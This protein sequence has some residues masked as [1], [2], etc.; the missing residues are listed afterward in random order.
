MRAVLDFIN[1]DTV[2]IKGSSVKRNI[3][4][5]LIKLTN[6]KPIVH[7]SI[8][9]VH[10]VQFRLKRLIGQ[11]IAPGFN[12]GFASDEWGWVG[13]Q[14]WREARQEAEDLANYDQRLQIIGSDIDHRMIRVAQD[15]AEE[16]G[17]GDLI[18]FKQMQV[19]DFTTKEDYGYVVTNPP[20]GERLSEKALVEQLYKE[21]G[22]VFRPLDTWSAYVLTSYEAFEKCYG[23]DAS[24]K[25]K[26]FNGFIRTDYYQYFG[27]R[28][29]R[30]S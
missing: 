20:Y 19:K 30:N 14:N 10:Q 18:T 21:M 29:P 8:H 25:R 7:L 5:S 17:L 15:N 2:W 26:L 1:V 12:R 16:V 3:S 24:K 23:K 4:A 9:S 22:Q 6:W 11:N 27:K 28:P 13:K